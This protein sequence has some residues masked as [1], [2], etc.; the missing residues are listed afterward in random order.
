MN[1]KPKIT[2]RIL[3]LASMLTL[4]S[5]ATGPSDAP[6]PA[7]IQADT[8][9]ISFLAGLPGVRAV[10]LAG[11]PDTRRASIRLS[12]PADWSFSTG[13]EP[14]KSVEIYVL[15]GDLQLGEFTMGPGGYAYLP[16]GTMGLQM[17]TES[18]ASVLYFLDK[19]NRASV[20]RTPMILSREILQWQP[21]SDDLNDIGVSTKDL[22]FDPGSGARTSL[23]RI[24][25]GATRPWVR[26][27]VS[28][29]GY[30]IE[31]T[32][33]HSEC[34][35]GE[36]L[37]AIYMPGGFYNRPP[38]AVNGSP[39]SGGEGAAVWLVRSRSF[40]EIEVVGE[41]AAAAVAE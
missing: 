11:N 1:N 20:I 18:G 34:V 5:C 25:A 4:V 35:E 26:S 31:G 24:E 17:S 39:E 19:D 2:C 28:E 32:Y 22:R 21:V 7:F 30:L 12:L 36:E 10:E 13:A 16:S 27:S 38:Q 37:T 33:Q 9:P 8:M 41:C 14:D 23:L 6:Y 29:E 3:I 40:A 15:S